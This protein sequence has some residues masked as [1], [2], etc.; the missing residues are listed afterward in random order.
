MGVVEVEVEVEEGKK[1]I[2]GILHILQK[3]ILR[4]RFVYVC[5]EASTSGISQQPFRSASILNVGCSFFTP[6]TIASSIPVP[7]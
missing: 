7:H 6:L 5:Y 3:Y 2:V 4:T 1:S